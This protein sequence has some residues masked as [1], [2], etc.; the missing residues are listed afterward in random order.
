M[1][2]WLPHVLEALGGGVPAIVIIALAME[3]WRRGN[4]I[5][6]LTDRMFEADRKTAETLSGM[7][8]ILRRLD[9]T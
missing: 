6:V 7:A 8:E 1:P 3:V 9:R 4:R 2:E 5:D